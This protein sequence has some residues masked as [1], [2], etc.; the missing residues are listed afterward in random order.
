[1][2]ASQEYG[3]L[4]RILEQADL[5]RQYNEWTRKQGALSTTTG[6]A[7]G[8]ATSQIPYGIMN[9]ESSGGGLGSILSSIGGLSGIG[10]LLSGGVDSLMGKLLGN[11]GGV[12]T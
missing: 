12:T 7:Q 10:S 9:W 4:N 1:V 8:L 6:Q 11:I 2:A 3:S 5:D